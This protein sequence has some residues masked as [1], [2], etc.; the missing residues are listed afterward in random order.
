METCAQYLVVEEGE[1]HPADLRIV[2]GG[3]DILLGRPGQSTQPDISFTNPLVSRKH[4]RITLQNG[5]CSITDLGSKHGTQLNGDQLE[6]HQI[7]V[8]NH[9]DLIVLARGA[10]ILR[11]VDTRDSNID[12]TIELSRYVASS[13]HI[14]TIPL[15][16]DLT[17]REVT[18]EGR[19]LHLSGKDLELLLFLWKNRNKAVSFDQ[20]RQAIWSE[21]ISNAEIKTPDVGSD[22]I[23][24]LV[25]RLRKRLGEHCSVVVSIPRFG[26]RLD[27]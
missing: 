19:P 27:V 23:T 24:A 3:L 11:F 17:R 10:A 13:T 20:I 25:Y 9:N 18:L 21:R 16:I 5:I 26:Y 2:L 14:D 6:P 8:L 15:Y 12:E 4:A 7:F 1:P 22:E